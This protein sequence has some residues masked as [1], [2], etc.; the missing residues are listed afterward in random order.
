MNLLKAINRLENPNIAKMLFAF[1][2]RERI[3]TRVSIVFKHYEF[4]LG[5]ILHSDR[6]PLLEIFDNAGVFGDEGALRHGLWKAMLAI[7]GAVIAIQTFGTGD[8]N[9]HSR[10]DSVNSGHFDIKPA[11]I[12][13][14]MR[15]GRSARLLLTDFDRAVIMNNSSI[16]DP[17]QLEGGPGS[18]D[19][20]PPEVQARPGSS[21]SSILRKSYDIWSLGC[22]LLEVLVLLR[23]SSDS[24]G[25]WAFLSARQS[26]SASEAECDAAF[27]SEDVSRIFHLRPAVENRLSR[28]ES[29]QNESLSRVSRTIRKMLS[30]DHER[31]PD[32][33]DCLRDFRNIVPPSR[34]DWIPRD[35][36]ELM[37]TELPQMD[38]TC[39]TLRVVTHSPCNLHVWRYKPPDGAESFIMTIERVAPDRWND[40]SMCRN[41]SFDAVSSPI[42][43]DCRTYLL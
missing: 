9:P 40:E 4:N 26:R 41:T 15:E 28:L 14:E 31:R 7:V 21:G 6:R 34:I 18:H 35:A 19:Y 1:E 10:P 24:D 32:L 23:S 42:L 20:A 11:N 8:V 16:G 33:E 3:R 36:R 38:T 2:V 5:N 43:T 27:W 37:E 13:I 12:L 22:V 25:S 39:N 29:S 30:V 17:D